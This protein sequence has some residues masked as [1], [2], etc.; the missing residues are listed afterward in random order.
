MSADEL[1]VIGSGRDATA[2]PSVAARS[3]WPFLKSEFKI[4]FTRRRNLVMLAVVAAFPLVMGL[5]LRVAA[6][7]AGGPASD[8]YSQLAGNGVYLAFIA[9]TTLIILVLPLVVAVV[10]GD[11][12][13][14]EAGL[15]TLRYLLAAPTGRTR[16][17]A[18][19]YTVIV[20][21]AAASTLIVAAVGTV[22]GVAL[23]SAGP[24]ALLSGLTVSFGDGLLRVLLMALY[25]TAALAA[26]GAIGMAISAFTEHAIGAMAAVLILSVL[27]EV[28]DSVPQ[29]APIAPYLPTH[30]WNSATALLQSPVGTS[31]LL[32]GLLSFAVYAVLACAI[33][34]AR[35]TS[36]D[37]TS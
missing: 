3:P 32:H 36:T 23:F 21:F 8:L 13:A 2:A 26:I 27:S 18:V 5:V 17:I 4:V 31:A 10:A 14:G 37:V 34:W 25:L 6:P 16:L 30:W 28:L 35:F 1:D 24:V 29:L 19:K 22:T 7:N 9:L 12:I 20:A 11:S 15:G 33:A